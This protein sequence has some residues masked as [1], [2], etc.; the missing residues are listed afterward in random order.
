MKQLSFIVVLIISATLLRAQSFPA[1]HKIVTELYQQWRAF[2]YPPSFEGAPD[3]RPSTFEKRMPEF[4]KQQARLLAQD[5]TGWSLEQQT[6]WNTIRAEM[7]GFDFNIRVL[8]PWERD[9]AFYKSVWTERSDVPAHEGPTMHRTL[10]TWTYSFP[11]TSPERTRML[12]ALKIIPSVTAQAMHNLTGNARELWIAG[13]IDIRTQVSDL[14][15]LRGKS[16]LKGDTEMT[17][18]IDAA[19]ASTKG[20]VDW[21][22]KESKKKTGASGI[23]KENYT[24][25]QQNVNLLPFTWDDEVMLLKRELA[26]AWSALKLEEQHNRDL[27]PL[28][29]VKNPGEY[30]ERAEAAVHN[31]MEFLR[32]KDMLTV[33][34]YFEPAVMDHI[35]SFVPADKRNFFLITSHLDPRPLFSH[36]YHWFEL[37]RMDKEPNPCMVRRAPLLYNIFASRNEGLAT[38]VEEIFMQA[39]LYDDSPRSR[40]IVYIMLAQRAARGLGSLYAQANLMTM[41]EAGKLHMDYTPRGWM[42]VEKGFAAIEQLLYMRQPG[43]GTSYITGKY[44]VEEAMADYAKQKESRGEAFSVRDFLDRVSTMGCIPL[45]LEHRELTG[46]TT[47]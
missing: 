42:K 33:K 28:Q 18:A 23:G 8:R 38:A 47:F 22:E 13:T 39:G 32:K 20:F 19:L 27:P 16:D 35:G 4:R 40:E 44:L 26:R 31:L 1:S 41:E 12:D 29:D 45:S 24:W 14:E 46:K 43:Y 5:T 6:D 25:Y 17:K 9:P 10:E 15:Q 2:E 3:Y 34:D 7:N 37:S 36:F 30:K 11:L 21:L